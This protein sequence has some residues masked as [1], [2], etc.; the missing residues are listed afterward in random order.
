MY[1]L[2]KV[3]NNDLTSDVEDA[4]IVAEF[5]K[6]KDGE[7]LTCICGYTKST[8]RLRKCSYCKTIVSK[9]NTEKFIKSTSCQI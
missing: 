9:S 8:S 5:D 4:M 3:S 2:Q 1:D 7:V 6:I